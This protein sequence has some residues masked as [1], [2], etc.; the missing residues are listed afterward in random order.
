MSINFRNKSIDDVRNDFNN[1]ITS[2]NVSDLIIENFDEICEVIPE[3]KPLENFNQNNKYHI[4][5]VLKHTLVVLDNTNNDLVLRLSALFHDIAKPLCYTKDAKGNGH[6]YGHD[7]KGV[8]ITKNIMKRLKYED[9]IIKDVL[10][11]VK[12]HDYQLYLKEA[13]LKKLLS[14]IDKHLVDELFLLKRADCLGQ[15]PEY[16]SRLDLVDKAKKMIDKMNV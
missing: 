13:P 16:I 11:L 7:L 4:Y 1:L 9:N 8:E 6:F 10:Q 2:K 12:Y 15:N 5:D 3:L 14:K